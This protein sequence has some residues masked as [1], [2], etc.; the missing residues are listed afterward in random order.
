LPENISKMNHPVLTNCKLI[1]QLNYVDFYSNPSG[2]T[3]IARFKESTTVSADM[4]KESLD[5]ILD[6]KASQTSQP[7]YGITDASAKSLHFT[8]E[9]LSYYREHMVKDGI[10]LNAIVV[11]ELPIKVIANIYARFDKPKIPTR[12]FTSTQDAIEWINENKLA[13]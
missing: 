2:D 10:I 5:L 9:A 12:V 3:L 8:V 11:K 7:T 13:L 6:Y 4:A 1:K